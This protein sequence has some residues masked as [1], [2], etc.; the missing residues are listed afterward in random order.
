MQAG[1]VPAFLFRERPCW[2]PPDLAGDF[3]RAGTSHELQAV[4]LV[5]AAGGTQKMKHVEQGSQ[6]S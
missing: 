4:A 6:G 1:K 5:V 2:P 3:S